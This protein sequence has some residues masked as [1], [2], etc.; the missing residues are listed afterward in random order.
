MNHEPPTRPGLLSSSQPANSSASGVLFLLH[1]TLAEVAAGLDS[2]KFTVL[3]LVKTYL[4]RIDEVDGHFRSILEPNL[5]AEAIARS[6][7]EEIKTFRRR[8]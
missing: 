4:K 3:D 2:G 6:L 1:I 7:D 5:R 8:R